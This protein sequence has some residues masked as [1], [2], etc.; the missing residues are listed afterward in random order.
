VESGLSDKKDGFARTGIS[1]LD[2]HAI[3]R[4]ETK[5]IANY[6]WIICHEL[7]IFGYIHMYLQVLMDKGYTYDLVLAN[8]K[9]RLTSDVRS[10]SPNAYN[11]Q[12][13]CKVESSLKLFRSIF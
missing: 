11:S 13:P 3:L 7:Q 2:N 10:A 5:H 9:A 8:R 1:H 4:W 12:L 6:P